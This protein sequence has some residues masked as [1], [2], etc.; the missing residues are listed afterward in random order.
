MPGPVLG[1]DN[2]AMSKISLS[3]LGLLR[4]YVHA[5]KMCEG[6]WRESKVVKKK[7]NNQL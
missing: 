7:H 6:G 3:E 2:I 1:T 5:H 4:V